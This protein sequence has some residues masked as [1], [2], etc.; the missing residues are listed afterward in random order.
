MSTFHLSLSLCLLKCKFVRSP[1][2]R[3]V[4]PLL[5]LLLICTAFQNL[6]RAADW[7]SSCRTRPRL[8]MISRN[9][10]PKPFSSRG[11][12]WVTSSPSEPLP[13]ALMM[14]LTR[15]VDEGPQMMIPRPAS[16]RCCYHPGR[17]RSTPMAR[18]CLLWWHLGCGCLVSP[19][20]PIR[21]RCLRTGNHL[22][23]RLLFLWKPP[24]AEEVVG[25]EASPSPGV[26]ERKGYSRDGL[27]VLSLCFWRGP[28]TLPLHGTTKQPTEP[29]MGG[30]VVKSLTQTA[31][32]GYACF[33]G[34]CSPPPA[35]AQR[36]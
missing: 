19:G 29:P 23:I 9:R 31:K 18:W 12:P 11:N 1:R 3:F 32:V 27:G 7:S 22:Q 35:A 14:R 36:H 15:C 25:T 26:G 2:G 28:L 17:R 6:T 34:L 4:S 24:A 21:S 16:R 33:G 10:C 30:G 20:T 5:S 13:R 8:M